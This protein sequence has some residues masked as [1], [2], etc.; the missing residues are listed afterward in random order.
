MAQRAR[1]HRG[2]S[3]GDAPSESSFL[4]VTGAETETKDFNWLKR[5][6]DAGKH[7]VLTNV[8]SGMGVLSVM[9]PRARELLQPLTPE[10]LSNAAFPFATSREIELGYALVRASRITYVGELGWELYV[11]TEFMAGVYEEIVAAG[12]HMGSC[13]RVTTPSIRCA[14]RKPIAISGMT[15][16]TRTRRGKRGSGSR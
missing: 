9:G 15:S 10:D 13:M 14:S 8:T 4:I 6:I 1:R 16:P 7:C 12:A 2:G 5:H 3:H 11:P